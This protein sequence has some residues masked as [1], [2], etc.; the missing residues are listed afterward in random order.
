MKKQLARNLQARVLKGYLNLEIDEMKD[1]YIGLFF[2]R[3]SYV[4]KDSLSIFERQLGI[5][6]DLT[7]ILTRIA[8]LKNLASRKSWPILF[9][10]ALLPM[11]DTLL[12]KLFPGL[13]RL[14]CTSDPL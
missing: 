8:A 12:D 5:F 13:K 10:T 9:M 11:L 4:A 6:R 14:Q 2:T 1:T 3:A 7:S